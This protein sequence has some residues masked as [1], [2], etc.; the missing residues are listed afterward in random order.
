MIDDSP[1]A[2]VSNS[3]DAVLHDPRK[4]QGVLMR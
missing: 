2:S 1:V 3:V 4:Y